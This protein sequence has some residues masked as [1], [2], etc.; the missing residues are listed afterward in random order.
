MKVIAKRY[1]KLAI[2]VNGFVNAGETVVV[3]AGIR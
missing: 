1:R 3:A 2:K